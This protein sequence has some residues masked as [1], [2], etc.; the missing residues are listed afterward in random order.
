MAVV[1]VSKEAG[2]LALV[3]LGNEPVNIMSLQ[4]WKELGAAVD[5]LEADAEV[6][7]VIFHSGLKKSVFTAGLD[8]KELYAPLTNHERF[9]E[10]WMALSTAMIKIYSSKMV[11][12]AAI[13]GACPAGG[14]ML[15]LCCDYRVITA[16]GSMG[17]NEV[18][19]GLPV[20]TYW[21]DLFKQTSGHRQAELML[22]TG[23]ISGAAKLLELGLV[24]AVVESADQVVPAAREEVKKWITYPD[25][26][27]VYTKL[28]LRQ[29]LA[30]QWLAGAKEEATMMLN[31]ASNEQS[32]ATLG[33]TLERL[34]GG[35]KPQSKL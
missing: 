30:D 18:Q 21:I 1:T 24:D 35:K 26:G 14:C 25:A 28:R 27:R 31:I 29:P 12:A 5:A 9:T 4:L 23:A 13:K 8:I 19:I 22:E 15:S 10:Y 20:P 34:S 17:L 7:A 33:K 11:T 32:V 6:R 3:A 2:G 16:D